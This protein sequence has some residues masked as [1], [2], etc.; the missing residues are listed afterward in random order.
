M[1]V[2]DFLRVSLTCFCG[3]QNME[4]CRLC[5]EICH[6]GRPCAI[7]R[8]DVGKRVGSKMVKSLTTKKCPNPACKAPIQKSSGCKHIHCLACQ[9]HFCWRC[10]G[11]IAD[12]SD[13]VQRGR[14]CACQKVH[15]SAVYVIIGSGMLLALPFVGALGV[16]VAPPALLWYC[17][18][19]KGRN[20]I[21][22]QYVSHI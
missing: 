2:T 20:W 4:T 21:S 17:A 7:P 11:S 1:L 18:L 5:H 12:F 16:V 13:P 15:A 10:R 6:P 8:A 3:P 22:D 14:P 19:S 9:A